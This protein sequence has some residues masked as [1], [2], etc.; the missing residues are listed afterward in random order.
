MNRP[1]FSGA[2]VTRLRPPWQEPPESGDTPPR[3]PLADAD[4][5]LQ[6][7]TLA[8]DIDRAAEEIK[9]RRADFDDHDAFKAAHARNGAEAV[10]RRGWHE[11]SPIQTALFT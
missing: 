2:P 6:L 10:L 11:N 4:D 7:G 8:Y 3:T 1:G 9:V 5:A